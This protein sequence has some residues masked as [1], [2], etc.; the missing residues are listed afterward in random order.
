MRAGPHAE[1]LVDENLADLP[2]SF[3]VDFDLL[4]LLKAAQQA[5]GL[6]T[7]DEV[8]AQLEGLDPD[9]RLRQ[10]VVIAGEGIE[11]VAESPAGTRINL[12]SLI[13][14]A[15]SGS[16]SRRSTCIRELAVQ[17]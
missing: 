4:E 13:T 6:R 15:P 12:A 3:E 11:Y 10:G 2:D 1:Q 9:A 16:S 8:D 14:D 5:L 7:T 17:Y